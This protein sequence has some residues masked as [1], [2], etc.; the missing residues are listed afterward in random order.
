M[1]GVLRRCYIRVKSRV[2]GHD[3]QKHEQQL[4]NQDEHD[5]HLEQLAAGH[6]RLLDGEPVDVVQGLELVFDVVLPRTE[7]QAVAR[8]REKPRR[9]S[10]PGQ[11][12]VTS[13][14]STNRAWTRRA[15]R[16]CRDPTH[17]SYQR[18]R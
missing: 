1:S 14:T 13:E 5:G 18:G 9:V 4:E 17:W 3:S 8:E 2:S 12:S 11:R 16:L 6:S 15:A 10:V 7:T